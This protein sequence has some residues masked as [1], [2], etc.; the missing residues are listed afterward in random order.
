MDA[1]ATAGQF[2]DFFC[3][4]DVGDDAEGAINN[5]L[6]L[7][8]TDIWVALKSAGAD[9]CAMPPQSLDYLAFLNIII[10]AAFYSCTCGRPSITMLSDDMRNNYRAWAQAQLDAVRRSEIELCEGETGA[11]FPYLDVAEQ[12]W[13]HF[14]R[15]RIIVNDWLRH[16]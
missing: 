15:V 7:A 9:Q 14:N 12:G 5:N 6:R 11:D 4:G 2:S 13:T 8:A 3:Q 1:Y 10:A 16:T